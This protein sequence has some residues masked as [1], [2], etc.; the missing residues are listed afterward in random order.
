M[1]TDLSQYYATLGLQPGASPEAVKQ[2]YRQLVKTWHP[3]RFAAAPEP[4]QQQAEAKIKAINHAYGQ[5]KDRRPGVTDAAAATAT[6]RY[7]QAV[8]YYQ[9]GVDKARQEQYVEALEELSQAIFLNP[10]YIE[11]YRHRG[12][13]YSI[14]GRERKADADLRMVGELKRK[15]G[16][17][18]AYT[19]PP[20]AHRSPAGEAA[21]R[22]PWTCAGTLRQHTASVTAIAI[23]PDGRTFASSSHDE[24][25]RLWQLSTGRPL[26]RFGGHLGRVYCV[27][28]DPE[29]RWVAS[30]GA[31]KVVR[32]WDLYTGQPL[33]TCGGWFE[34]HTRPVLAVA[35]GGDRRKLLS[36]GADATLRIWQARAG[37]ALRTITGYSGAVT[38]IAL[39][40][41]GKTLVT[42]SLEKVVKLRAF[43][44][45]Q[46]LWARRLDYRVLAIAFSPD[47]RHFAT[48]GSDGSLRLWDLAS[49]QERRILGQHSQQA[50]AVA[51]SPDGKTL[52]SGGWDHQL[53]FWDLDQ[54]AEQ[55]SFDEHRDGVLGVAFSPDGQKL[56]SCSAD[57]TI[58]IWWPT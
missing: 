4:Q 27:A 47:G 14:L 38:A 17:A 15:W 39:S 6:D 51:F 11:A 42:G 1:T 20:P 10:N 2:A 9:R 55:W 13:V 19:S 3:D 31:D 24:T 57:H 48:A 49:E 46:L 45:G 32:L 44:G 35:F 18:S 29:G 5:L 54:G 25:V 23:S 12:L 36:G 52:A 40:P 30:G 53:K 26:H 37:K 8:V 28:I 50:C 58:K 56:L 16:K 22:A 33:A 41:D 21:T 43:P 34:G 7:A